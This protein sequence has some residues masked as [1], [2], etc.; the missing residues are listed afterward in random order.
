M[1]WDN[2]PVASA[3]PVAP[4]APVVQSVAQPKPAATQ[5]A[6]PAA[7]PVEASA[8]AATPD[9]NTGNG[10]SLPWGLILIVLVGALIGATG[11]TTW[12]HA[13]AKLNARKN[14]K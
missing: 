9:L 6:A 4:V 7:A 11:R 13:G 1:T 10:R 2:T 8:Q 14:S 5:A 3:A 12:D